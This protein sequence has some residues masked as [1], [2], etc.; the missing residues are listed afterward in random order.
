M[1]RRRH[2]GRISRPC[3]RRLEL[4][5]P[6]APVH[7]RHDRTREREVCAPVLEA[8][9]ALEPVSRA[10]FR[11]DVQR[12]SLAIANHYRRHLA[13]G[14]VSCT[15]RVSCRA[16]RT[17]SPSNSTM[18]SPFAHPAFCRGAFLGHIVDHG[19]RR[20]RQPG[21]PSSLRLRLRAPKCRAGCRHQ[22]EPPYSANFPL[23]TVLALD[24]P[25]IAD[26]K[27]AAPAVTPDRA[28]TTRGCL[29]NLHNRLPTLPL[30][31]VDAALL[32][33]L[34]RARPASRGEVTRRHPQRTAGIGDCSFF[35]GFLAVQELMC[36][37]S[38]ARNQTGCVNSGRRWHRRIPFVRCPISRGLFV[39]ER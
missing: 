17:R 18:M 37:S 25:S 30:L 33:R 5:A 32:K 34:G 6:A 10:R 31:R 22:Q 39:S 4:P 16:L 14:G 9:Q 26:A 13:A 27:T 28:T 24:C 21:R 15:N 38:V 1:P 8:A 3:A 19:P 20:R 23:V 2:G 7:R 36:V 35:L 29:E 12:H 11:L